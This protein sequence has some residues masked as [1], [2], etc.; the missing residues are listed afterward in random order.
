MM[1]YQF[2]I[3]GSAVALHC[4]KN[5]VQSQWE[6][7]N[8]EFWP[9]RYQNPWNFSNF[10]L[11]SMI[12]S[13]MQCKFSFQS[14]QRASP[15]VGEM[16]RFYYFFPGWLCYFYFVFFSG[17]H[18]VQHAPRNLWIEFHGLWLTQ[19]IFAQILCVGWLRQYLNS[20]QCSRLVRTLL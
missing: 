7:A 3:T 11:T 8:F 15:Q 2:K 5:H 9:P 6:K 18:P 14:I 1:V 13:L 19:R 16:L 12:M 17:M 4:G 20:W 10:N